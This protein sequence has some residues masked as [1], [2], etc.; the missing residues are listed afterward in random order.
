MTK[1]IESE[2]FIVEKFCCHG[3]GSYKFGKGIRTAT[4]HFSDSGGSLNRPD[5][6]T[7]LP[8]L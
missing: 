8:F 2:D 3:A 1:K 6:F 4:F 5:L 7:E